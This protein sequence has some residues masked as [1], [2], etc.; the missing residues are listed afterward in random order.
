M[1]VRP[2]KKTVAE[3][4][5]KASQIRAAI[6]TP[7]P[8]PPGAHAYQPTDLGNAER[9]VT[10]CRNQIHYLYPARKWIVWTGRNWV[11]DDSGDVYRRAKLAVRSIPMDAEFVDGKDAR[12]EILKHAIRSESERGIRAMV[13]CAQSEPGVPV[14]PSELDADPWVLNTNGGT[15]D[16]RTGFVRP[17]DP[18][19]LCTKL[20]PVHYNPDATAPTWDAFLERVQPGADMRAFLQRLVGY[21]LTG[22]I[23][24]HVLPIFYGVGANG[25]GTFVES[26]QYVMGDYSRTVDSAV[27][28]AKKGDAHPTERAQLLG[29]RFAAASETEEGRALAESTV[30]HLTGGDRVSA[31]FM[32]QDFFEFE[33]TH[34]LALCTN[35]KPQIKG[36]DKGIWRRV[37]LVPWTVFIPEGER[38]GELK[39]KLRAEAPGILAWAVRGCLEWQRIGL[40]PPAEVRA[41]T[42]QFRAES[43]AVGRFVDERCVR[44]GGLRVQASALYAEFEKWCRENGEQCPSLT[45]FGTTIS[46]RGIERK[47]ISGRKWYADLGIRPNASNDDPFGDLGDT[48]DSSDTTPASHH[49]DT[50]R[51]A[52]AETVSR[53]SLPSPAPPALV[54]PEDDD[55]ERAAIQ[56]EYS[57]E[58]A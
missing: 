43:D 39:E 34:K 38:D 18:L 23:R 9:L 25:K 44:R 20:S 51:A 16:L 11:P 6:D 45:A 58:V 41:A 40:D 50:F 49:T 31:R 7:T 56:G 27:L 2:R 17:H 52:N 55:E 1:T 21:W 37:L 35:H 46:E 42:E 24:D 28:M 30:K 14:L 5:S 15:L 29:L 32:R 48:S 36:T 12:A 3:L 53:V 57:D 8:R 26:V 13:T 33:P 4:H 19:D 22:V 47:T 54:E 10:M